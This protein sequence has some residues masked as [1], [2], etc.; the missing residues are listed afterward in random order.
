VQE[1][2][3]RGSPGQSRGS[4]IAAAKSWHRKV[5]SSNDLRAAVLGANDGLMSNLCPD[6]GRCRGGRACR[7]ILLTAFAGLVAGACSMALGEGLSV[8]NACE[9]ARTQI[10]KEAD[11]LEHT[12]TPSVAKSR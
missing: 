4:Q 3:N 7:S 10:A 5:S 11:G 6:H 1:V 2:A 8:T 9:L 12:P